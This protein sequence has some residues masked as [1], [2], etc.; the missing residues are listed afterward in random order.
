MGEMGGTE[1]GGGKRGKR[2]GGWGETA[3]V[4]A[5]GAAFEV[6]SLLVHPW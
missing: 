2:R 4:T 6:P 1:V 3:C 5:S